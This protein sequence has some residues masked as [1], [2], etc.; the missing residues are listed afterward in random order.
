MKEYLNNIE[1]MECVKDILNSEI[2]QKLDGFVQHGCFIYNIFSVQKT[3][4]KL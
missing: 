4:F 1:Y 3:W 2:F